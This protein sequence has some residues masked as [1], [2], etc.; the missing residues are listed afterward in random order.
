MRI[1]ALVRFPVSKGSRLYRPPIG[2]TG[3]NPV[4][5]AMGWAGST[6]ERFAGWDWDSTT[7]P[8]PAS[9]LPAQS[10]TIGHRLRKDKTGQEGPTPRPLHRSDRAVARLRYSF[11]STASQ[12][13]PKPFLPCVQHAPQRR[14]PRP[15][16]ALLSRSPWGSAKQLA[17]RSLAMPATHQRR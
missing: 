9:H 1:Q 8:I 5:A 13:C 14:I 10:R 16:E 11:R 4:R 17:S 12:R 6:D 2:R 7:G 15:G 3:P